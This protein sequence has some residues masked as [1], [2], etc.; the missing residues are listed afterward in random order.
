MPILLNRETMLVHA[1]HASSKALSDLA[2]IELAHRHVVILGGPDND[3]T[4]DFFSMYE[5]MMLYKNLTGE[6]A[7]TYL[8]PVLTANIQVL[9]GTL[10]DSDLNAFE[11]AVQSLMVAADAVGSYRYVKGSH[12]PAPQPTVTEPT[13]HTGQGLRAAIHPAP[14]QVARQAPEPPAVLLPPTPAPALA[15]KP[16]WLN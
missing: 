7:P 15:I 4:L 8:R 9:L 14:A 10:E 13:P 2:N 11:V 3:H 1:K 6:Q 12:K 5:L 16:P